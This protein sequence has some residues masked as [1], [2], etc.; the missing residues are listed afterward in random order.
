M[1][2]EKKTKISKSDF[3]NRLNKLCGKSDLIQFP[4]NH[5]DRFVLLESIALTFKPQKKYSEKSINETVAEWIENMAKESYLD[6]VTLRRYLVDFG[7]IERDPAGH[8]YHVSESRLSNLF[9]DTIRTMNPFALVKKF[10]KE[11]EAQRKK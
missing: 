6:H 10:R 11:R 4:K 5:T 2:S 7:L 1:D 9:E 8:Q 3:I